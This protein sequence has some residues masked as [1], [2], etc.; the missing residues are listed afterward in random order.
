MSDR[1]VL[2]SPD[3]E[4]L[5]HSE[6][7]L[8][9]LKQQIQQHHGWLSFD[10]YMNTVLY[11]PQ[12]GYYTNGSA[13]FGSSGDFVTAPVLSPLFGQT[14]ARQ[15]SP[16]LSQT[17]GN[18][19][20]FGAGDGHLAATLLK[21]LPPEALK[22]YYIIEL[23]SELAQRQR[24]YIQQHAP[25]AA[26]KVQHLKQLP[27]VFDGIILGNEVL[28]AMP[29]P[30]YRRY[31]DRIMEMG[32]VWQ[33][34]QPDWSEKPVDKPET[35][36]LIMQTFPA[37]DTVYQSELHPQQYAFVSTLA[38]KLQRGAMI[39]ID[40]GFDAQQ[41]YHPQRNQG[42]LIG[43]YRHH[44]VQDVFFHPGLMDL[45][46]HVNFTRIADAG[47]DH[48][49]DLIGYT[50]QSHFLLNLGI[51]TLLAQ[52][53]SPE[54]PEYIRAAAAC[55]T[56]LDQHEMGELFKVIAFGKNVEVDWLG[57]QQGDLCHKL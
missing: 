17:A 31:P 57:F 43:H 42:S 56:L 25:A 32:V 5:A 19:Y 46:A 15:I 44:T 28:D 11:A 38:Q 55:H 23:S 21:A 41:Y 40:Y 3:T 49:L 4:A 13:K 45:T 9:V 16:L 22:N 54:Q 37:I 6:A 52:T 12:H 47:V 39:W 18:M 26:A 14:L 51:T 24:Q 29:V 2:P 48:D 30:V 35:A 53:A 10:Q 50:T 34:N 36:A 20:E 7:L 33:N 1:S 27:A 8:A